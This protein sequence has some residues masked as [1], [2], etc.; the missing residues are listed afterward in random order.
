[1]GAVCAGSLRAQVCA[2]HSSLHRAPFRVAVGAE[3][4][5]YA[6]R[7]AVSAT[8]GRAVF[9]TAA[10]GRTHDAELDA[11]TLD[12][13]L[14]AGAELGDSAGRVF[15]CPLAAL[16]WSIGP[17]DFLLLGSDY[18]YF[19]GAVGLGAAAVPV[20]R[21]RVAVHMAGG[22]RLARL[23][24]HYLPGAERRAN[25]AQPYSERDNYWLLSLAVGLVVKEVL[26]I[27]PSV[28][29]PLGVET[30]WDAIAVPFGRENHELSL[31]IAVGFAFGRRSRADR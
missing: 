8:G 1:M 29:V 31:G 13:G 17:E 2:G 4:F 25:G 9:G 16:S 12:I 26:S 5:S 10:I 11:S 30:S 23:K 18:K 22:L 3:S 28:S 20:R 15:L 14:E 7:L 19:E 27:R 24:A 6:T 21:G